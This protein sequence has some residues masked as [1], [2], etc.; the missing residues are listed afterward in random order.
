MF[1]FQPSLFHSVKIDG[2]TFPSHYKLLTMGMSSILLKTVGIVLTKGGR[3]MTGE[4]EIGIGS[5]LGGF[6]LEKELGRGGMGVVYKAHELSLNRKVALKVL[7]RRLSSDTEF[8]ERFKREAQVIAALNHPNIVGILSYGEAHGSHY[9]AMEYIPGRDLGEVLKEKGSLPLAK[10]LSIASQVAGALAVAG[11]RGVVHRDLKPSNI[12]LDDMGRAKVT[13]FGVAHFQESGARLTQTGLFLGTPEYASPEQAAGRSLDVRSDI[14]ALGAVLYRMLSGK[15]PITGESPL[16]VVTKIATEPVTPIGQV[17]TALPE[18]VCRLIDKMMAKDISERFQRP[19]DV[20]A[21]INGCMDDLKGETPV[22][23]GVSEEQEGQARPPSSPRRSKTKLWGGIA[24]VALAVLLIVWLVEGGFKKDTLESQVPQEQEVASHEVAT[25]GETVSEDG[26]QADIPVGD[27]RPE[28]VIPAVQE[29][30]A[31][32]PSLQEEK[33]PRAGTQRVA[34]AEPEKVPSLP[35]VPTVLMV[36]SGEQSLTTL[37]QPHLESVIAGSG[38]PVA[39]VSEI[40]VLRKKMQYG[41]VPLTW[42][43]VREFVPQQRVQILLLAE[44]QKTGSMN[45]KYYGRTR[46]MSTATFSVRAVDADTGVSVA[47]PASGSV[48]YTSLNM[49]DQFRKSVTSSVAAMGSEIKRYWHKKRKTA[50]ET[51]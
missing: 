8:I 35:E 40:P 7:S 41:D 31:P 19:E 12:M 2:A 47:D 17:N 50:E 34:K 22:P 16:A 26:R 36:I 39:S 51:G 14:Y 10:A 28:E 23:K 11:G 27:K 33:A 30:R 44:V 20:L 9:F 49:T 45:L 43:S 1:R 38:L 37:V 13:D 15:P 42:Y 5:V 24:G 32:A 48:K 29:E 18:A 4:N 46:E 3:V 6:K 21:A 25:G